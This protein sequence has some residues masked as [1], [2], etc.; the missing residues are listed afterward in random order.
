MSP[1]VPTTPLRRA[2]DEAG[3]YFDKNTP[4]LH[5]EYLDS[6]EES[7]I[8]PPEQGGQCQQ[9]FVILFS[10][11]F[12]NGYWPT[13]NVGNPVIDNAGQTLASH[14]DAD[15]DGLL[16][17]V[18]GTSSDFDRFTHDDGSEP[19]LCSSILYFPRS[20]RTRSRTSPCTTT[21]RTSPRG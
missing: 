5:H 8:L 6:T 13:D 16:A 18:S 2:L 7:P 4:D 20:R 21:S 15:H 10:D 9:N 19:S 14:G 11:S 12:W 17:N 3:H 1:L